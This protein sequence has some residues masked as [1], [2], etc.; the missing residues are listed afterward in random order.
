MKRSLIR[1]AILST[2]TL[3]LIVTFGSVKVAAHDDDQRHEQTDRQRIEIGFKI[4]PV[5][6][7]LKDKNPELVGLGSYLVNAV[8]GCSDCHTNPNFAN[9]GNPF[10]GQPKQ[11]NA[12][13]YL[14]GGMAF[15]PFISRNLTPKNGLPAGRTFKEF[16]E[17]LRNGTDFNNPGQLLQVMPWPDY[18][19]MSNHDIR[20]IYE[21]LRSIPPATPGS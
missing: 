4:A 21:Y 14:A 20:A 1:S 15:G 17:V 11:I 6:P 13:N 5:P 12:T 18:Q 7:D 19:D 2:A 3:T 10:M 9:G 8:G 16:K